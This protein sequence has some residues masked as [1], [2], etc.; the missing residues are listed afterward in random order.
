MGYC[1]GMDYVV[2]HLL[3][4][5]Q[6]TILLRV[7]Q[8][9]QHQAN[10]SHNHASSKSSKVVG[11]DWRTISSEELRARMSDINSHSVVVEE[12][13]FRVMVRKCFALW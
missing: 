8:R 13:V 2:A 4:V 6:D 12:T 11:N 3:R 5:L 10:K 1:Q 7:V 9:Q